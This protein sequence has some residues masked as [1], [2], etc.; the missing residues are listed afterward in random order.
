MTTCII[1][2]R[3]LPEGSDR[4]ACPGCEHSM[5]YTL[6]ALVGELPALRAALVPGGSP[7]TGTRFGGRAN[8]PLPVN[9]SVLDLLGPG[10]SAVVPDPL[11]EQ[12]GG[13]PLGALLLGWAHAVAREVTGRYWHGGTEYRVPCT[14]AVRRGGGIPEWAAWLAA[15][16]PLA[17]TLPW[18]AEMH[19]ELE[20]ALRRVRAITGTQPRT[21][22]RLAPCP[23]CS[24]CAM[25]RTDGQWEITCEAC[26][27]RM[28][29]DAYDAHAAA[30]L[31]GLALTMARIA[32]ANAPRNVAS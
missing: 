27:H 8:A 10:A 31:P 13:V 5:R 3:S 22:P 14:P 16:L 17:A 4:Y 12:T 1:C 18:V 25:S 23:A 19:G 26:G 28:D 11:G 20:D 32:T 24:A 29:P 7:R 15:Y 6:G 21:H 30:V 9:V 2:R